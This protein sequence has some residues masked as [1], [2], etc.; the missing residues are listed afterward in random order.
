M[1]IVRSINLTGLL[2]VSVGSKSLPDKS[3]HL[4][5]MVR[6]PLDCLN[7]KTVGRSTGLFSQRPNPC[8][9]FRG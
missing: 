5:F 9:E 7:D 4:F 6:M 1:Y 8:P 2:D 3:A